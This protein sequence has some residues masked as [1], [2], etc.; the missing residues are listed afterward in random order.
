M[1]AGCRYFYCIWSSERLWNA[2]RSSS[3]FV[4]GNVGFYSIKN[5]VTFIICIYGLYSPTKGGLG[6]T[7]EATLYFIKSPKKET[8]IFATRSKFPYCLPDKHT[9]FHLLSSVTLQG[10]P[11]SYSASISGIIQHASVWVAHNQFELEQGRQPQTLKEALHALYSQTSR[12][13][14]DL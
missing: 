9:L 14:G 3:S 2:F 5:L 6:L 10:Q 1:R 13:Q 12:A 8:I 4:R 11:Q 7:L